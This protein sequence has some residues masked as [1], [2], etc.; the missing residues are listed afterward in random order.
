VIVPLALAACGSGPAGSPFAEGRHVARIEGAELAY[1]VRGA[2][3]ERPPAIVIAGGPGLAWDYLEL[4]AS[5]ANRITLVHLELAGTGTA[6][7]SA[8]P[9]TYSRAR[10]VADVE[11][12]RTHLEVDEIVLIGHSYG[13][14]VALE[15]ALAHPDR[16]AGLVLYDTSATSGPSLWA[17]IRA[18]LAA[19]AGA[20]WF[21][22]AAAAF[23]AFPKGTSDEE[24]AALFRRAVPLYLHEWPAATIEAWLPHV[25]VSH[26]RSHLTPAE[27]FDVEARLAE[28]R[29]PTLVLVGASD[30]VC[31]P[32]MARALADGIA[33]AELVVLDA[34][35]HFGHI[36]QPDAFAAA[37]L[38]FVDRLAT[39]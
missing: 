23:A 8:D 21:E 18:N 31:S 9:S 3:R 16:V 1:H 29:M 26:A 14:F 32:A 20:P 38:A 34:S 28:L 6:A 13:G 5:I 22:D 11:A 10:D 12:L 7:R 30:F 35:G 25:R 33:N 17:E 37:V 2:D 15:Y 24:L 27:P 39:K 36:E 4:P 19:R